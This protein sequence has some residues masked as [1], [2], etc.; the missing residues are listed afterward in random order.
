VR[1]VR[2]ELRVSA[3]RQE[4][5]VSL[6]DLRIS[7]RAG[8]ALP[9]SCQFAPRNVSGSGRSHGEP[10]FVPPIA[11]I[12][13]ERIHAVTPNIRIGFEIKIGLEIRA[14][15]AAFAKSVHEV[16]EKRVHAERRTSS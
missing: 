1:P 16:M 9:A 8:P 11:Q 13:R 15:I 14:G 6:S 7:T 4:K 10:T 5:E 2:N 3:A 12:M